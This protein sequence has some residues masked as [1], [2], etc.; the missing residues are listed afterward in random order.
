M[1]FDRGGNLLV[2]DGCNKRV[3]LIAV[4][5][6]RFFGQTMT[7]GD[8]YT[9][10]GSGGSGILRRRRARGQGQAG[11]PDRGRDRSH[12]N[13]LIADTENARVRVIAATT[14]TFYGRKM[15]SGR[16]YTIAGPAGSRQWT[17]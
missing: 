4:R 3:R 1:A 15:T 17:A 7:A 14:G 11:L 16:I 13:V 10:A 9:I 12:G 6:G 8:V 5:S 2:A